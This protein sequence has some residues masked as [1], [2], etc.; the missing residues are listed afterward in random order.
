MVTQTKTR[1]LEN[2]SNLA[3]GPW[4]TTINFYDDRVRVIQSQADN[5][6]TGNDISSNR[7]DFTGKVISNYLAHVNPAVG[8][9][10]VK[11][12]YEYDFA[13]RLNEVWKTINNNA[14]NASNTKRTPCT[15]N[16]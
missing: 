15:L 10:S 6:R 7:Y 4:L 9:T 3:A 1:V 14:A 12:N 5:Y 8:S 13:G 16:R 11:T 2:T